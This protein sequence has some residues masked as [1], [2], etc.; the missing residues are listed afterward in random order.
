MLANA[1]SGVRVVDLSRILAGPWCTQNLADLGADVLKIERPQ[2]GD[3]TRSW[4]PP[5]V[6]GETGEQVSAYF[7]SCN[8]GK[9]SVTLDFARSAEREWLIRQIR[10]ADVL[11]ENYKVG[12]LARYGLDFDSMVKVNPRLIYLSVTGFGQ[13][14]PFAHKPGY[15]YIFQGMGGLMGYTGIP[16]GEEGA[17]PL[18]AGVAVVDLMTGMY[19][20]SAVLAALIERGRTG[21]GQHLDIALFDVSVA[22]N[23]NQGANYLVSGQ[24]PTRSGNAHPNLAPYEV[25][26]CADGYIIL[27]IGNDKQFASF[28]ALMETQWHLDPRFASNA[29]RLTNMHELRPLLRDAMKRW[30]ASPLGE[31]LDSRGIS[32]GNIHTMAQVFQHP[33]VVHRQMLQTVA[34]PT[35]GT[36]KL[37]RNPMVLP[38]DKNTVQPPPALGRSTFKEWRQQ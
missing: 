10:E 34:H 25:F 24:S 13:T 7:L 3:D 17:G 23:A 38:D 14:G 6:V 4:G 15:D 20:T 18:R 33:Q 36:L 30:C 28:C 8:R 16:D 19:A 37:V 11:V 1:L 2:V 27:A 22:M 32:W 26:E 35:F 29:G 5:F 31:A 9:R 12:D 21:T